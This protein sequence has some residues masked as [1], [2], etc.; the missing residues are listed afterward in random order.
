MDHCNRSYKNMQVIRIKIAYQTQ[1]L[2]DCDKKCFWWLR[3]MLRAIVRTTKFNRCN[4]ITI[5]TKIFHFSILD[6][7]FYSF[8][9][10]R[11]ASG[12]QPGHMSQIGTKNG[13]KP[14]KTARCCTV[15]NCTRQPKT[16]HPCESAN[17]SQHKTL[18]TRKRIPPPGAV[19][20]ASKQSKPQKPTAKTSRRPL[21]RERGRD[22]KR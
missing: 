19:V 6:N 21:A 4:L 8:F 11:S 16:V 15:K 2:R 22:I 1:P 10:D 5:L 12:F 9:F 20:S 14:Y 3:D 7:Y 13:E 18:E 17:Q